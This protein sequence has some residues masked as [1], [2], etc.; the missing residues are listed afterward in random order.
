MYNRTVV[1]ILSI[2]FLALSPVSA[3]DLKKMSVEDWQKLDRT[4]KVEYM[5]RATDAL[6]MKDIPLSKSTDEYIDEVDAALN[7]HPEYIVLN[8]SDLLEIAA[9]EIEPDVKEALEKS[10]KSPS[11]DSPSTS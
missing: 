5:M 1:L 6:Q 7:V 8:V 4:D 10:K 11:D 9:S 3:D 2:L